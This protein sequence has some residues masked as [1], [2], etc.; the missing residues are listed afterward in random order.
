[1][2]CASKYLNEG[3]NCAESLIKFYNDEYNEN[4]PLGLGSGMGAGA[5]IGSLCGAINAGIVIIGFLKG[6]HNNNEINMARDYSREFVTKIKE[7]YSTEMCR[8][9]K[10]NKISCGEIVDFSYDT[11]INVLQD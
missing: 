6:R 8:E 9:L 11:L 3:Y 10:A 4:I 7:K 2:I 1:M 5:G